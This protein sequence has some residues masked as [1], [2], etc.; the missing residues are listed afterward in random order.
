MPVED[1]QT[2]SKHDLL[3][4]Y[5]KNSRYI[6]AGLLPIVQLILTIC[7]AWTVMSLFTEFSS[8]F[9]MMG[10]MSASTQIPIKLVLPIIQ[11]NLLVVAFK[12]CAD[13]LPATLKSY[14]LTTST[15]MMKDRDIIESV[16][17]M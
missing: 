12:V 3:F 16:I 10:D 1:L 17:Q 11:I 5:A 15:E 9:N 8:I 7:V 13:W 6:P 4:G 14:T 2:L